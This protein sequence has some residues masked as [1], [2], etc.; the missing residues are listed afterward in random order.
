LPLFF[1][2]SSRQESNS[3]SDGRMSR[4]AATYGR[5]LINI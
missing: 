4:F 5:I 3:C 1:S 2:I